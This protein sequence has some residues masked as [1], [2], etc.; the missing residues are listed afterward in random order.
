MPSKGQ[1]SITKRGGGGR[2]ATQDFMG[3]F[4]KGFKIGLLPNNGQSNGKENGK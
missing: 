1:A 3:L 2:V 4:R